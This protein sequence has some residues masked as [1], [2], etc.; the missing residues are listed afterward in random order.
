MPP[1]PAPD[2]WPADVLAQRLRAPEPEV[3][4][5]AL[6]MAVQSGAPLAACH[7]ALLHAA[8][9]SAGDT[10]A[11]QLAASA[12][13]S[14]PPAQAQPEALDWLATQCAPA[15]PPAVRTAAAHALY[16]LQALP[17]AAVPS[18]QALLLD[19]DPNARRVALL[20]FTPF[21][22]RH[23]ASL[24]P[25]VLQ[26][27]P[28]Q[29]TTELLQALAASA[30]DDHA[31]RERLDGFLVR[32]LRDAPLLPTA[33]AGYAALARLNPRGPALQALLD[34]AAQAPE[35][36]QRQAALEALGALGEPAQGTAPALARL[37]V[38]CSG[39][40]AQ[41]ESLCRTLVR[42]RARPDDMP[43]PHIAQRVAQAPDRAAAAHCMLLC[44]HP[45]AYAGAAPAVRE[46]F[47]RAGEA[48][49]PALSQTHKALAGTELTASE[50]LPEV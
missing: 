48:L 2:L 4:Q 29:W 43:L 12:L 19:A 21:A 38:A 37:L 39:D 27:P 30:G 41:E 28:G 26:A 22:T 42:V 14:L 7:E 35:A 25:F 1:L 3:R 40:A 50:A 16:R 47:T 23:A 11:A 44:L 18:V 8:Q 33:I 9:A 10:L 20:A 6:G 5:G 32:A 49:R 46:R 31:A 24:A 17:D 13:G 15:A 36:A 34:V 45:R